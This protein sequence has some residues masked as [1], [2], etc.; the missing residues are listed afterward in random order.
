MGGLFSHDT[1]DTY[2]MF[3]VTTGKTRATP[4][5]VSVKVNNNDLQMEVDTGA[6]ASV[7]SEE[8]YGRL[9]KREDAPPLRP[10]AVLLRTY[11][12]EKLALLGSI[13]V[14]VQY[15]EQRRTLSLLVVA[16]SG[17]TLLGGDWLLQIQLDWTN[18][19][20]LGS[21]PRMQYVLSR[22]TEVFKDELGLVKGMTAE[23]HVHG[24]SSTSP[25]FQSSECAVRLT[26][27]GG[28]E[29]ERLERDGIIQ[30]VQFSNWAAPI[31]PVVPVVKRDGAVRICGDYKVTINRATETNTYPLPRIEDLFASLARGKI[32][33]K[34]DLA[35]AYQQI[36][37]SE[38]SKQYTT[39]VFPESKVWRGELSGG[40]EL[41]L[42]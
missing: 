5:M 24:S 38:E 35:H 39:Q 3:K 36:A 18:L 10:T 33:S 30:P 8:T 4:L 17:P 40:L 28:E 11:A 31:V 14:D 13:T 7:I 20:H 41:M 34:L 32:F 25:I 16:G 22:H 37:L 19:K 9:W 15:Q 21:A 12:G 6:S 1:G 29:L 26:R 42:T 27:K 23:I 2:S